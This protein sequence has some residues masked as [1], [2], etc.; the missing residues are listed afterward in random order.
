MLIL[1]WNFYKSVSLK[2]GLIILQNIG[3]WA[4]INKLKQV[5][6]RFFVYYYI[7]KQKENF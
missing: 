4:T 6:Q 7:N 5:M 1:T 2:K 3:T